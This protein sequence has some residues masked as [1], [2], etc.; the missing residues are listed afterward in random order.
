MAFSHFLRMYSTKL[1]PFSDSIFRLIHVLTYCTYTIKEMKFKTLSLPV[2]CILC[3]FISS[4]ECIF[5]LKFKMTFLCFSQ[6]YHPSQ[7]KKESEERQKESFIA[8]NK[9]EKWD[10]KKKTFS[11]FLSFL[12]RRQY[13]NYFLLF[14][15]HCTVSKSFYSRW[16]RRKIFFFRT[17]WSVSL[18][19]RKENSSFT[20][21]FLC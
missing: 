6:A 21:F 16:K 2:K 3:T 9:T 20:F 11:F 12:L 10:C 17:K 13:G 7:R 1:W 4:T 14:H 5:I 15:S 18:T 8:P 19:L